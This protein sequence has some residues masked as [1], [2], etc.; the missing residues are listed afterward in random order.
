MVRGN[1]YFRCDSV[2]SDNDSEL[3]MV[4]YTGPR[5][6]KT[7]KLHH[8]HIQAQREVPKQMLPLRSQIPSLF[9]VPITNCP[10]SPKPTKD[11][12]KHNLAFIEKENRQ[13]SVRVPRSREM[14]PAQQYHSTQE[15][16]AFRMSGYSGLYTPKAT[17]TSNR[18]SSGVSSSS[19]ETLMSGISMGSL[20]KKRFEDLEDPAVEVDLDIFLRNDAKSSYYMAQQQQHLQQQQYQ[21]QQQQI[22][23]KPQQLLQQQ[24]TIQIQ[25]KTLYGSMYPKAPFGDVSMVFDSREVPSTSRLN[26][27]AAYANQARAQQ[28]QQQQNQ[29]PR[30]AP[31]KSCD[32]CWGSYVEMCQRVSVA[33]PMYPVDGPWNWHCLFD[34]DGR[35]VCPR[36]WFVQ[37]ERA[38]DAMLSQMARPQQPQF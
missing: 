32:Y 26:H 12:A 4:M 8:S 19:S 13:L 38:G 23:L 35:V 27:V 25:G 9:S 15:S 14:K 21:Q 24:N 34:S 17:P 2:D 3:N 28:Q 20:D 29:Q 18:A 7:K 22:R 1:S 31:K 33:E 11:F 5:S 30:Q 16:N 6:T 10:T 37:V 36:L